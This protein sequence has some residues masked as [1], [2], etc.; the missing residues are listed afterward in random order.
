MSVQGAEKTEDRE[1][2]TFLDCKPTSLACVLHV[3]QGIA[4]ACPR[5]STGFKSTD[6]RDDFDALDGSVAELV[7]VRSFRARMLGREEF[8]ASLWNGVLSLAVD[9]FELTDSKLCG[10]LLLQICEDDV[11]GIGVLYRLAKF[12]HSVGSK[13]EA[14]T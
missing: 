9:C 7:R 13:T 4:I 5:L 8:L 1:K 2:I 14:G 12:D 3:L 10:K 11:D 6:A